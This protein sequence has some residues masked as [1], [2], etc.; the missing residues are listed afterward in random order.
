MVVKAKH[1]YKLACGLHFS[2][3]PSLT[4]YP[5]QYFCRLCYTN[6]LYPNH[7]AFSVVKFKF[8]HM[9]IGHKVKTRRSDSYWKHV[10]V[11]TVAIAVF[12]VAIAALF[13]LY[14]VRS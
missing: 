10:V 5:F 9:S 3:Q 12:A 11:A 13:G 14:F 8:V 7:K 4:S 2:P 1:P 6:K